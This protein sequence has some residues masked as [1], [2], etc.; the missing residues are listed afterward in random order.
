MKLSFVIP[1]PPFVIPASSFVIPAKAG[2]QGRSLHSR[3][4]A[5]ET[6]LDSR[7]RGNDGKKGAAA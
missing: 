4:R 2:I 5:E 3:R 6:F 1:A 7:F